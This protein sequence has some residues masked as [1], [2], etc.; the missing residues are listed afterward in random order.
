MTITY[1]NRSLQTYYL[2]Q[3]TTKT[4]KPKYHFSMKSE[5]NLVD[6]IPNGFEIYENPDARVFL[7]RIP[8]KIITEAEVQVVQH[9]MEQFSEARPFIIDVKKEMIYI[10]TTRQD[11]DRMS[12]W[13]QD[14]AEQFN[15]DADEV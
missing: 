12:A 14:T 2:H 13:V 15:R 9:G 7:R 1:T 6:H 4:G 11:I 8:K 10:F 5:G 3:G